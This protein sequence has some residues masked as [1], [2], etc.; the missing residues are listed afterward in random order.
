[1]YTYYKAEGYDFCGF[2]C[3]VYFRTKHAVHS[4]KALAAR[5]YCEDTGNTIT[6]VYAPR[7]RYA[8]AY[9]WHTLRGRHTTAE[10]W[11]AD[12]VSTVTV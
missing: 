4:A 3:V 6:K 8:L 5:L 9:W 2:P 10:R 12:L 1:M 7:L 11:C